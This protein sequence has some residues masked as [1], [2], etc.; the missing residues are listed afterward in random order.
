MGSVFMD[1]VS[2]AVGWVVGLFMGSAAWAL[3]AIA[4]RND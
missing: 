1:L 2:A 3:L 4:S